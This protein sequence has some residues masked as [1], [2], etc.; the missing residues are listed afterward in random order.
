MSFPG[1]A[2]VVGVVQLAAFPSGTPWVS[3]GVC[4]CT[5]TNAVCGVTTECFFLI[6]LCIWTVSCA[7]GTETMLWGKSSPS[8]KGQS[9]P[10]GFVSAK[11]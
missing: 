11:M 1:H 2:A 10:T 7:H 5:L 4:S 3:P 9:D 6:I 8:F